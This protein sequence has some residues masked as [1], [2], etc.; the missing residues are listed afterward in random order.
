ISQYLYAGIALLVILAAVFSFL[1]Y[2]RF[3]FHI[4]GEELILEKGI[5]VREKLNIPFQRI[6]TVNLTQNI[7]QQLL[8]ITGVKIDTAGSGKEELQI[9]ALKKK[10]AEELQSFLDKAKQTTGPNEIPANEIESA[11]LE[12]ETP[13]ASAPKTLVKLSFARLI[14]LGLTENHIRSG[15]IAFAIFWGY[16]SQFSEI[17]GQDFFD[18]YEDD[19]KRYVLAVGW[20][21]TLIAIV[22]FVVLSVLTSLVRTILRFFQLHASISDQVFQVKAGLLKRNEYTIPLKKVQIL[23]WEDNPLRRKLGFKSAKIFQGRSEENVNQ[24]KIIEIPACYQDQE[25]EVMNRLFPNFSNL[26]EN[27]AIKPHIHQRNIICL[28]IGLPLLLMTFLIALGSTWWNGLLILA[29]LPLLV[30]F[31][32]NYVKSIK[33]RSNQEYFSIQKGYVFQKEMLL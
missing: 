3:Q 27:T 2:R 5:F 25:L 16:A 29:W 33:L 28:V 26:L 1:Q 23:Q 32:N 7:V 8:G 18:Q 10:D 14:M 22:F 6:Q 15:F 19:V 17:T 12:P 21:I 31:T 4:Q 9:R 13:A 11:I 24:K 20:I 30:F